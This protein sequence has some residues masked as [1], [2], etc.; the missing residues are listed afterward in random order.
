M[1]PTV[2][3]LM[4]C[5]NGAQYLREALNSVYAQTFEDWELIFWMDGA[6]TDHSALEI[7]DTDHKVR[8]FKGLP[9]LPLGMSRNLAWSKCRGRYVALLDCDDTW[10][11]EKLAKQVGLMEAHPAFG[12]SY[13][14]ARYIGARGGTAFAQA[15]PQAGWIAHALLSGPN[16]MPSPTLMWRREVGWETWFP[17]YAYAETWAFCLRVAQRWLVGFLPDILASY[18][19][20]QGQRGGTGC[21]GMTR[22]VLYEMRLHPGHPLRKGLLYAKYG[23]QVATG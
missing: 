1:R 7:E 2:S 4:N 17:P 10:E 23:W 22:E 9:H 5:L 6:T 20:H 8:F 11:P 18:R 12:M 15:P 19:V 14:N 13:T 3:I 21:A 16:F